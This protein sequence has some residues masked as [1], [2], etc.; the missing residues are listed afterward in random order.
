MEEMFPINTILLEMQT[1]ELPS[2]SSNKLS[3]RGLLHT[4]VTFLVGIA[5]LEPTTSCSQS[6]HTSQLYYIP[7]IRRSRS[8]FLAP[9]E[10]LAM[11]CSGLCLVLCLSVPVE[12]LANR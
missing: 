9:A 10:S 3:P 6:T 8:T 7:I 11:C 2:L 1:K 12:F 4:S 5:G